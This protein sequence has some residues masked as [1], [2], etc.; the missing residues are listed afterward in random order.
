MAKYEVESRII[1]RKKE[2]VISEFTSTDTFE[3]SLF[4][5][6]FL[7]DLEDCKKEKDIIV[8]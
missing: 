1:K 5:L 2:I 6:D 4:P 3:F 8:K 7:A